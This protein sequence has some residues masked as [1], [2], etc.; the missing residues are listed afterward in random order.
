MKKSFYS[1]FRRKK[2]LFWWNFTF[3][4]HFRLKITLNLHFQ[5]NFKNKKTSEITSRAS[6]RRKND[7]DAPR[8][9]SAREGCLKT[10]KKFDATFLKNQ[11]KFPQLEKKKKTSIPPTR[12][13][14]L[15]R[16]IFWVKLHLGPIKH[17]QHGVDLQKHTLISI[18]RFWRAHDAKPYNF[19]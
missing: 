5:P 11:K 14:F 16:D 4:N 3:S 12:G 15:I 6:T 19:S 8:L 18:F 2:K 10:K 7:H 13:L 17:L 1:L 9:L